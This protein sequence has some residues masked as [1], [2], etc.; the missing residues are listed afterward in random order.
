MNFESMTEIVETLW[1]RLYT[2]GYKCDYIAL[3]N[4]CY[5]NGFA[6]HPEDAMSDNYVEDEQRQLFNWLEMHLDKLGEDA[7]IKFFKNY[8][9]A[10]L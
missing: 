4:Y 7:T 3:Q 9:N 5:N 1:H 2:T 10:E 8:M 6:Y